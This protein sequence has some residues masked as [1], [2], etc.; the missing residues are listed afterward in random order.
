MDALHAAY[1]KAPVRIMGLQVPSV[2]GGTAASYGASLPYCDDYGLTR[3]VMELNMAYEAWTQEPAY[4][5][6]MEF[7][8][9]SG[10]FDSDYNMPSAER[11]VNTRNNTTELIGINGVHPTCEGYMQIAD[12]AF[13]NMVHMCKKY[14]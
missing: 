10:Q 2:K 9:I 5:D 4:R 1:P 6:F 13:R 14:K 8:N 3:Y 12:A 11:N 7:I